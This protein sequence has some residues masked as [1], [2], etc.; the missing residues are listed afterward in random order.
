MGNQSF[1]KIHTNHRERMKDRFVQTDGNG[2]AEHELLEMLLYYAVQRKDTNSLAHRLIDRFGSLE[3]VLEAPYDEL[4][5]VSGA[6]R[7]VAL[8]VKT[9]NRIRVACGRSL[10]E[11]SVVGDYDEVGRFLVGEFRGAPVERVLIMLLDAKNRL[12]YSEFISE[13]EFSFA[14]ISFRRVVSLVMLKNAAKVIISHNHPDGNPNPS[15]N[16][17]AVTSALENLLEQ[18]G[19]E[20]KEHYIVS[21]NVYVGLKYLGNGDFIGFKSNKPPSKY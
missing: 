1:E 2:F 20:L 12:I 5:K 18:I 16:D 7:S 19:V 3:Q 6:G 15:T 13:G 21:D 17:R 9:V 4:V 8:L 11:N 14:K 10:K